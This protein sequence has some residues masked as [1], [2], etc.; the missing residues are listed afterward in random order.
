MG[1]GHPQERGE[2]PA[3]PSAAP[4]ALCALLTVAVCYAPPFLLLVSLTKEALKFVSPPHP[5]FFYCETE[6]LAMF[7]FLMN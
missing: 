4:L 2:G 5:P 1:L 6:T 3:Q 7:R